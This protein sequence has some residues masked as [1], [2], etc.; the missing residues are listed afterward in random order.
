VGASLAA[1]QSQR[2]PNVIILLTDD[3][4]YGDFSA[5]G[6]PVLRTPNL[7]RLRG[8]SVRL[9]QFHVAPMC[10]PTRGQLMSGQHALANMAMNVSAGRAM[11]RPDLPTMADIFSGAGYATGIFGKWHLGDTW[12]YRPEDRGFN[13]AVWFPSSHV[14]S[15][16]DHWNN[17]YFDDTYCHNGKREEFK[18]YCTDVFFSQAIDWMRGRQAA[19]Q[20]FLA[21]IPTNAPHGPLFVPDKWREGFRNQPQGLQN[22]FGM[23]ANIDDNIGRLLAMLRETGLERDTIVVFFT[24]NGGTAGVQL[25][26][27]GMRGSKVTLWEGGHRVPCFLRWPGGLPAGRDVDVLAQ[28]Q[29]LLPTLTELCGLPAPEVPVDGISLARFLRGESGAPPDRTLIVQFSRMFVGRPQWGDAA[30]LWRNWRLVSG[31]GLY[32]ISKDPAQQSNV[33]GSNRVIAARMMAAYDRWWNSVQPRF[34]S[35][36]P[37]HIGGSKAPTV[38]LSPAD[39]ADVS[40]DQSRDVRAGVR[41]NGTWHIHMERPGR[42]EF[43]V[44]RWPVESGLALNDA[45]P[46][47]KGECGS[48]PAGVVLPI[49]AAELRVHAHAMRSVSTAGKA[50]VPF[51]LNL[52]EG[53][54]TLRATF[55]DASGAEICGAY[56]VYA[57]RAVPA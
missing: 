18:G 57:E 4:G 28:V 53:R 27:A 14:G 17:D 44:A 15:A 5:H 39:W 21:Y 31:E 52:P 7:D 29:D 38:L 19:G 2:R 6:N 56:Y 55:L 26:N 49:A 32:D 3:Q 23:I 41:R 22:F 54:S 13:E 50:F 33:I 36:L 48:Y 35:F 47:H 9:T 10:T 51:T 1:A 12:P 42:Y 11:L 25:H 8:E 45:A 46:E 40:L 24:D 20:P 30:V 34:D 43:R 37:T 16:P